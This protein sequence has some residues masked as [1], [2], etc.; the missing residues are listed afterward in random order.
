M[1]HR[2]CRLIKLRFLKALLETATTQTEEE[3]KKMFNTYVLKY[4]KIA[5]ETTQKTFLDFGEES[6]GK[7]F[8]FDFQ[9]NI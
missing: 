4:G 6:N 1:G 5:D 2:Y 3:V 9:L 8:E 7:I